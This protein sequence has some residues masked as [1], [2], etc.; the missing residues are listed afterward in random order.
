MLRKLFI[1][2]FASKHVQDHVDREGRMRVFAK[3]GPSVDMCERERNTLKFVE[4]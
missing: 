4:L 3:L 2:N 1:T